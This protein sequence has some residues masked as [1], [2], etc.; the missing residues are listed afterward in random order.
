MVQSPEKSF[1]GGGE[2][3][4]LNGKKTHPAPEG[5]KTKLEMD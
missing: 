1:A 5:G 2:V 4:W 3:R